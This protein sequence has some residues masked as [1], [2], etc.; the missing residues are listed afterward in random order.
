MKQNPPPIVDISIRS[1]RAGDD[2]LTAFHECGPGSIIVV[3]QSGDTL[4]DV[5]MIRTSAGWVPLELV[6]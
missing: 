1:P 4:Q 2:C 3:I 5:P 6:R